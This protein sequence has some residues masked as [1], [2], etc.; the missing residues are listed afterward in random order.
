MKKEN[1][2]NYEDKDEI[3]LNC[4]YCGRYRDC[5]EDCPRRKKEHETN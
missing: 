2:M 4:S 5:E 3:G 1:K